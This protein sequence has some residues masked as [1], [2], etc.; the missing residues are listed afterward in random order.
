MQQT[1]SLKNQILHNLFEVA[2]LWEICL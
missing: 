2:V 1:T